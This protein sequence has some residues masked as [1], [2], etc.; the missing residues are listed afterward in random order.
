MK[1]L[2][3]VL[4]LSVAVAAPAGAVKVPQVT[5]GPDLVEQ[6]A[7]VEAPI[8]QVTV[9]SDRARIERAGKVKSGV[10]VHA[11]RLPDLPGGTLLDTVRVDAKGAKVLRVEAR[12]VEQAR[13]A[14]GQVEGLLEQL[15]A[16]G[17]QFT[18]HAARRQVRVDEL[19]YL[20]GLAPKTPKAEEYRKGQPEVNPRAWLAVRGFLQTR[21][22]ALSTELRQMDATHAEWVEQAGKL[23]AEIN[24]Y[25]QSA[26]SRRRTIQVL[27]VLE[28]KV[29]SPTVRLSYFVPGASWRPAYKV[30]LAESGRK[31]TIRTAGRVQQATGED[32]DGVELAL[33][34]AIPGQG[35][36]APELLTWTLGEAKDFTP[37]PQPEQHRPPGVLSPPVA[38]KTLAEQARDE[39]VQS[40]R[41]RIQ[42]AMN[43]G[44]SGVP[45]GYV[46][47]SGISVGQSSGFGGLAVSGTG[48]GGGGYGRGKSVSRE[49]KSKRR[50]SRPRPSRRPSAPMAAP[51]PVMVMD[52]MAMSESMAAPG[53]MGLRSSADGRARPVGT[54]MDL[55]DAP[56]PQRRRFND[57]TL[58]AVLAGGLDYV[59]RS[60]TKVTVPSS[61]EQ[62]TVPLSAETYPVETYYEVSPG[63]QTTA[64]LKAKVRNRGALPILGGPVDIFSGPNY[65]GTGTLDSTGIGG[66]LELP[67]GADEDLEIVRR[68]IPKTVTEGVFSKDELTKYR[69][70]IEVA[71]RKRRGVKVRV[72]EQYPI[73]DVE[74]LAIDQRSVNPK[75]ID[76]PNKAGVMTFELD[77]PAGKKKTITI[78]Y[79][80]KR[81]ENWRLWQ[82]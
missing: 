40:L 1:R 45:A 80:I 18:L 27:V 49:K 81:P 38:Q 70:E 19:A 13:Q 69:T 8:T 59:Y 21:R 22:T 25:N 14:I 42:L 46:S 44:T 20:D 15:E 34:T 51:Q 23:R 10:G 33:S 57:P 4:A 79:R 65:V 63:L 30:S 50:V 62:H 24:R 39:A 53:S 77:V 54:P 37:Q 11:V 32:W 78:D 64:Y 35:I 2:L 17:K 74:D 9:F 31:L 41:Q 5:A 68:V 55:F 61:P 28:A 7:A 52:D 82:Q 48:R 73:T 75:P 29:A 36:E 67:L 71:N 56:S 72:I 3:R 6:A 16:L 43:I 76:G 26:F 66:D 12:P 58:P 60:Q 47:D